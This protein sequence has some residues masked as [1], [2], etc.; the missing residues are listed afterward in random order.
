[1]IFHINSS[2]TLLNSKANVMKKQVH[3]LQTKF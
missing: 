3:S 1:M 2:Y